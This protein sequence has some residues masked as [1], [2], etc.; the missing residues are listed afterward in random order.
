MSPEPGALVKPISIALLATTV[1]AGCASISPTPVASSIT[2]DMLLEARPLV[3]EGRETSL[4]DMNILALDAEMLAFL[5]R[6]VDEKKADNSKLEQLLTAIMDESTL[7]LEYG[8]QTHTAIETFHARRGNCLS[9]TIMFVAMARDVGI[10]ARF[11]EVDIPPEWTILGGT[12]VLNRH[13][14]VLLK[15]DSDRKQ[16]VDFNIDDFRASYDRR[17]VP[18]RRIMAH[19]YNNMGVEKMQAGDT[20][21]ALLYFRKAL[22]NDPE[23]SPSWGNLGTLYR[24]NGLSAYAEAAYLQAID[25]NATDLVAMSNLAEV[26]EQ[27][28]EPDRAANYRRRVDRHRMRNPYYRFRLA[29]QAYRAGDYQGSIEHLRFAIRKKEN[30][31][32]FYAL[33]GQNYLKQGDKRKARRWLEKAARVAD[34]VGS[35]QD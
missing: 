4:P 19:Y 18:D 15:L 3:G 32:A 11:Q 34:D 26:Y 14:N 21:K 35:E 17:Q 23:F 5:D 10:D 22:E 27:R 29:S 30:E 28:G 25:A 31:D 1:L 16:V 2:A 12:F 6:F 33:M 8:R 20:G 9:F 7:G 13:V 24:R